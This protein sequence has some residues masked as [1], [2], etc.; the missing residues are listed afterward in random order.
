MSLDDRLPLQILDSRL[1]AA[2]QFGSVVDVTII[3]PM[4]GQFAVAGETSR[5]YR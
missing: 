2:A 3:S 5:R 1:E 4:L